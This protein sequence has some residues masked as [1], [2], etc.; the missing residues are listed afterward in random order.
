MAVTMGTRGSH[1][2]DPQLPC[3]ADSQLRRRGPSHRHRKVLRG[4]Q[5]L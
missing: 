3:R 2:R 1:Y 5:Y 4:T